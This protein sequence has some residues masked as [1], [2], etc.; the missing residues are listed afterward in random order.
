MPV[1][2]LPVP[3]TPCVAGRG[4]GGRV[5]RVS[6]R[7]LFASDRDSPLDL[8]PARLPAPRL[9]PAPFPLR[10]PSFVALRPFR[11]RAV[12]GLLPVG[13]S[14]VGAGS[15]VPFQTRVLAP[16][17]KVSAPA[18]AAAVAEAATALRFGVRFPAYPNPLRLARA[19][20]VDALLLCP[21]DLGGAR[22]PPP[23]A[24]A[25]DEWAGDV[26]KLVR[27]KVVAEVEVGGGRIMDP[28][29]LAS[30]GPST[31]R[32]AESGRIAPLSS[33]AERERRIGTLQINNGRF[34]FFEVAPESTSS[35]ISY[36]E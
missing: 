7:S 24:V 1:F 4:G 33:D 28:K 13:V 6:A 31:A 10:R 20:S 5:D 18:A 30:E 14:R 15:F 3:H 25:D 35:S 34:W 27:P 23:T 16:S 19:D 36:R 12:P 22:P 11:L 32:L 17:P 26:A 29:D 2:S 9:P 8:P 21:N